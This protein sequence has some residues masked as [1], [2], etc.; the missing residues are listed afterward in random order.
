MWAKMVFKVIKRT[1]ILKNCLVNNILP[2]FAYT[3]LASQERITPGWVY[4]ESLQTLVGSLEVGEARLRGRAYSGLRASSRVPWVHGVTGQPDVSYR[5]GG[6]WA[7][8]V[9]LGVDFHLS[10]KTPHPLH[11]ITTTTFDDWDT[12]PK[13]HTE[14]QETSSHIKRLW[15]PYQHDKQWVTHEL[16]KNSNPSHLWVL[17]YLIATTHTSWEA[18][19]TEL[20]SIPQIYRTAALWL[21]ASLHATKTPLQPTTEEVLLCEKAQTMRGQAITRRLAPA[22]VT[23]MQQGKPAPQKF[24]HVAQQK[25]TKMLVGY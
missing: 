25:T 10:H 8:L 5:V 19:S 1:T 14:V 16:L 3:R 24:W 17:P 11:L 21:W 20:A 7:G 18:A 23:H 4:E 6:E 13:P 2:L 22:P 15:L 12:T 9:G